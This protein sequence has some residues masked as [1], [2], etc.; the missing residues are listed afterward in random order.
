[1]RVLN[2]C[3]VVASGSLSYRPSFFNQQASSERN[4]LILDKRPHIFGGVAKRNRSSSTGVVCM[5]RR[6]RSIFQP[7]YPNSFL[8]TVNDAGLGLGRFPSL[9]KK[10]EGP[11]HEIELPRKRVRQGT[12][13]GKTRG[14]SF[15]GA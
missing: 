8:K 4:C 1:V 14:P 2:D 5:R 15:F 6:P 12:I 10:W 11:S 9:I 7:P 3:V 13:N